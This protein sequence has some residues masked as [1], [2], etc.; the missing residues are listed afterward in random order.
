MAVGADTHGPAAGRNGGGLADG[1][2]PARSIRRTFRAGCSSSHSAPPLAEG[3]RRSP[4]GTTHDSRSKPALDGLVVTTIRITRHPWPAAPLATEAEHRRRAFSAPSATDDGGSAPHRAPASLLP[5]S[6]LCTGRRLL[7]LRQRG[8]SAHGS[9]R[10]TRQCTRSAV[11]GRASPE[12]GSPQLDGTRRAGESAASATSSPGSPAG[13]RQ[14]TSTA[15]RRRSQACA[16]VTLSPAQTSI[17][18]PGDARVRSER[19]QSSLEGTTSDS[20]IAACEVC[21][22]SWGGHDAISSRFCSATLKGALTRG[23]VCR[24]S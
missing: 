4:H 14:T 22:H 21:P 13:I 1:R 10:M 23:C 5:T 18:T 7:D 9:S 24:S 2:R 17:A 8:R 19:E 15:G 3:D 6:P 12:S 20:G 11:T 16:T